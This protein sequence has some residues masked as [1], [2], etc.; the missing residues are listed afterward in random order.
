MICLFIFSDKSIRIMYCQADNY[1]EMQLISL[2]VLFFILSSSGLW[3][4]YIDLQTISCLGQNAFWQ[5]RKH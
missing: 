2:T 4:P 1:H 5:Q 3:I